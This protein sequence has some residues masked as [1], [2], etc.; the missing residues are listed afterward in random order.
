MLRTL[1]KNTR[2]QVSSVSQFHTCGCTY[3]PGWKKRGSKRLAKLDTVNQYAAP[4]TRRAE[5]IYGWG[6]TLFGA[7]GE[8]F[9]L[10]VDRSYLFCVLNISVHL[11]YCAICFAGVK[12][13]LRPEKNLPVREKELI[14]VRLSYFDQNDL[15]VSIDLQS[16]FHD[17]NYQ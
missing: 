4:K 15:H 13:L 5:R 9:C 6:L 10:S 8:A 14:P 12:T 11:I 16:S 7:L 17:T 3:Y 2:Y 1:I